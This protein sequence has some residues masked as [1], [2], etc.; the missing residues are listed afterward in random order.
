[1]QSATPERKIYRFGLFEFDS[2]ES[3]LRKGGLR[4]KVQP[5]PLKILQALLDRPGEL[6]TREELRQRLWPADTFV[7][8]EQGLNTAITRL[9]QALGD[10]AENPRF[11]GTEA[12]LGYRMIAQIQLDPS[13]VVSAPAG[14]L[15]APVEPLAPS[16]RWAATRSR[17]AIALVLTV[18]C[19]AASAVAWRSRQSSRLPETT[20]GHL[21]QITRNVGLSTDPSVSADGK[22]LVYASDRNGSG[23]LNI[24]VQQLT[25]GG[26]S[27]QL[28][29]FQQDAHQPAFSQ[30]GSTIV[31]RAEKDGG[32]LYKIPAIG[33]EPIRITSSGRGPRFSPDGKWIAYW[34][35][36][37]N[38]SV[39]PKL[40]SANVYVVSAQGGVPK[41]VATESGFP[42]WSPDS[43]N[44]MVVRRSV[45]MRPDWWLIP[46][47][48]G[49]AA[50]PKAMGVVTRLQE[51]GFSYDFGLHPKPEVWLGSSVVF[52]GPH[53][54]TNNL[55]RL[56]LK[57][58]YS[59]SGEPVERLTSG[60][61]MDLKS[62]AS[63]QGRIYFASLTGNTGIWTLERP[64]GPGMKAARLEK[65]T[66][67]S[68]IE[69]AP[70][71]TPDGR[72]IVY[73]TLVEGNHQIRW[74][75]LHTGA[76]KT[77]AASKA[78][79]W[80]PVISPDGSQVAF[81]GLEPEAGIFLKGVSDGSE[82][83][84]WPAANGAWAWSRDNRTV[85]FNKTD[86]AQTEIWALDVPSKATRRFLQRDG[87]SLF[88]AKFSPD[89]KW[90]AVMSMGAER[91][92]LH[93]IP[94][95]N[96]VLA[97]SHSWVDLTNDA[98]W[99]DKPRWSPDGNGLYYISDRDG[100]RCIWHQML[101]PVTKQPV[102]KPEAVRHFHQTRLSPANV[103]VSFLELE[104]SRDKIYLNLGDLTG[105]LWSLQ[106]PDGMRIA[107]Q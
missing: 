92:G 61:A 74:K 72:Y 90:I 36:P 71:V 56:R 39:L 8:F 98:S 42:I 76:M 97:S 15:T 44:L 18:L 48:D 33:G 99:V 96:G 62:T 103:S 50:A 25:A 28:T 23:C 12:R 5:Q 30:D 54:D 46:M 107:A 86:A 9:R 3:V 45:T 19:A 73:S 53:G 20:K 89:E 14:Q 60:T 66:N 78:L 95:R 51:A 17:L 85:L 81:T 105:N 16:N 94:F 7:D 67:S 29:N 64:A 87:M 59:P 104:V 79:K 10:S 102:G 37:E 38:A 63:A 32:G 100:S 101:D 88:Q 6:I 77:L 22:L 91:A 52:S 34:T 21:E 80:H 43:R 65:L 106:L 57:A 27:I 58:D 70:S 84:V 47:Q 24:W 83:K 75:D 69:V 55:W 35:T 68:A 13:P 1:V 26:S 40:G 93:L 4:L 41:R 2:R 49:D 82:V 11:I 31:F